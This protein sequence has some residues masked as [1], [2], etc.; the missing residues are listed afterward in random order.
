MRLGAR[1]NKLEAESSVVAEPA[2]TPATPS[3]R[4]LE[5]MLEALE[6]RQLPLPPEHPGMPQVIARDLLSRDDASP[7]AR[8]RA[9]RYLAGEH[10]H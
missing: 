7:E 9:Q 4:A 6:R 3:I 1:L 8:E 10:D 2:Y 5:I